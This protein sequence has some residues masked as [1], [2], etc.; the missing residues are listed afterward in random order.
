MKTITKAAAEFIKLTNHF[1]RQ[2]K[3]ND[4]MGFA[5]YT[6]K[7]I[8]RM[9]S[10]HEARLELENKLGYTIKQLQGTIEIMAIVAEAQMR[11]KEEMAV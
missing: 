6:D 4:G 2:S 9:E 8:A 1:F 11:S 3:V 5:E 10:K 7:V